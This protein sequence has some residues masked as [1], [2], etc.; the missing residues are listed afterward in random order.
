MPVSLDTLVAFC[1][2]RGFVF[3]SSDIYGGFA[4]VYDYGHY[5]ILLKNNI[6]KL[7]WDSMLLEHDQIF[8]LDAGIFMSPRVW[9]AS[10][11][12]QSFS[13]PQMDCRKCKSRMR[14][15]HYLEKLGIDADA[16]DLSQMNVELEKLKGEGK[17]VCEKCGAKDMTEARDFNLLVQTN[18]GSPTSEFDLKDSVYPRGE[19]CQ[20]IYVNFKNFLDTLRVK[21]P[22]GVAQVGK[23]FRNE[24]VARQFIFRTREFEQMEMQYFVHEKDEI[25]TYDT[26][27]A[28][29]F[30][31][32]TEKLGIDPKKIRKKDHEKLAHYAK[33][34]VDI[35]Y[36]FS[37]LGGFKEVEG[38][39]AR[40]E[41]DLSRH[42]E[43]SKQDLSYLDP[44]TN[45]RFVPHI[46]ETSAGLARF[47][48]MILDNTYE[49][50]TLEDASSRVVLRLP[51]HLSPVKVAVFPLK[52]TEPKLVEIARSI[53]QGLKKAG[54]YAEYDETGAIGKL[55]RRQD[56]IGTPYC[57]TVDFDSMEDNTVTI[58]D[59]DTMKQERMSVEDV[60]KKMQTEFA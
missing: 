44:Y 59:R 8:G 17:L 48:L 9:E 7:W 45:E 30:T 47:F 46:V 37:C 52:K 3:P 2:R 14:V 23:A 11:H 55:Y 18:L 13:D 25:S 58:R 22:F 57:I 50:E 34:A 42:A 28:D 40:G 51:K 12:T 26:W 38:V 16:M 35:E 15:D 5:G 20:G 1:K 32:Y 21:V 60:M 4:A 24:I 56:E 6:Q 10:G 54:I 31:W 36:D 49:E 53:F 27:L 39:H 41:W 33:K 29:R 19:T 43:F